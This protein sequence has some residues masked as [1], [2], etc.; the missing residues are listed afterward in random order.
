M[1]T[2]LAAKL[3]LVGAFA[4]S[5]ATSIAAWNLG[6]GALGAPPFRSTSSA[7]LEAWARQ[8]TSIEIGMGVVRVA[9]LLIAT[10]LALMIAIAI[11]D[12]LLSA[13]GR[14]ERSE[15]ASFV[16]PVWLRR[17]RDA[18]FAASLTA[19]LTVASGGTAGATDRPTVSGV[20]RP[21][22]TS[23]LRHAGD[24]ASGQ[25]WPN[26]DGTLAT[27]LAPSKTVARPAASPSSTLFLSASAAATSAPHRSLPMPATPPVATNATIPSE[28]ATLEIAPAF[29]HASSTTSTAPTRVVRAGESFWSI[30]EDVILNESPNADESAIARYWRRLVDANLSSL[31]T[32]R[33]P[34]RLFPGDTI[35]LP[36]RG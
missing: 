23:V 27:G 3:R 2:R 20:P 31:R 19:A 10:A 28:P 8:R 4:L 18:A 16:M 29:T 35:S 12:G 24:P 26:F 1:I 6:S 5:I 11:L 30:A 7:K 17:W 14:T 9:L 22:A 34:D 32:P 25:R 13:T 15:R 33:D 21:A 36:A